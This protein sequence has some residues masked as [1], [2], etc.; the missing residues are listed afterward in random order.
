MF[1]KWK[2]KY[3]AEREAHLDTV[4]GMIGGHADLV[5]EHATE[6]LN[7]KARHIEDKQILSNTMAEKEK[8][9]EFERAFLQGQLEAYRCDA[10]RWRA[11]VYGNQWHSGGK[12][13]KGDRTLHLW[14]RLNGSAENAERI[15]LPEGVD[16]NAS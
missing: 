3:E 2:Q 14:N 9:W 1:G 5:A 4:E 15:L 7:L 8:R 12:G 10:E 16:P 11:L 13:Q 6:L